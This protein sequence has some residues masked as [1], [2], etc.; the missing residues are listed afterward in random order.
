ME[1]DELLNE[2]QVWRGYSLTIP[3]L[4][5]TR[6]ERRGPRF[7]KLGKMVRYRRG[8]IEEYLAANTVETKPASDLPITEQ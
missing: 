2:R 1:E 6:R 7:L 5:R 8:D 4:R 3:W